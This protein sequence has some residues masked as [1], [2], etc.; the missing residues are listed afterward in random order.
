MSPHTHT[1]LLCSQVGFTSWASAREPAQVF[2]LL[3]EIYASFD[4]VAKK[5][6]VFKVETIGGKHKCVYMLRSVLPQVFSQAIFYPSTTDCY[7]AASGLPEERKDHAAVMAKFARE[8]LL[9]L[10]RVLRR[11]EV[12]L[13]PETSDLGLRVGIHTGPVTAGVLRGE[14]ARFQLFG[15]TVNTAAR[16]E[17]TG[18]K[19]K[20]QVS[21]E[22]AAAISAANQKQIWTVPLSLIH[23]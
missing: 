14:K 3:E 8:C 13:G 10:H 2:E 18:K 11:L 22:T 1:P 12:T 15:D 16:M 4:R 20:I 9:Q 5:G 17:S 6:K 21:A 23:I 19:N 7:M